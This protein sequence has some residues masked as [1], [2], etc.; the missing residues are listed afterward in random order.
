MQ[1]R[2]QWSGLAGFVSH[3]WL[4]ME[5]SKGKVTIGFGPATVP[6]IDTGQIGIRDEYGSVQ[7]ISGIHPVTFLT[8]PP[9]KRNYAQKIGAGKEVG[10][11]FLVSRKKADEV[12]KSESAKKGAFLYIPLFNDCRTYVC[13]LKAKLQGKSGIWCHLLFKG[14]W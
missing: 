11:P 3:H 12:I 1:L 2:A 6:F 10:K 14:Y 4:E 7:R 9:R 13:R 5:T 8:L